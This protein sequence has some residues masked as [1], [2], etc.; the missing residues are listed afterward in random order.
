GGGTFSVGGF[1]AT[2]GGRGTAQITA[3]AEGGQLRIQHDDY[4]S[5]TGFDLSFVAGGTDGSA[6]LGVAAGSYVGQDVMGTIGGM[7]ATGLGTTLRGDEGTAVDGLI[8]SYTGEATGSA[9][10]VT[11]S[12]GIASL[13]QEVAEVL[14]GGETGSIDDIVDNGDVRIKRLNDRVDDIRDRLQARRDNL[15]QRF[16]RLEEAMALAQTQQ[17]WLSQQLASLTA[18]TQTGF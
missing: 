15:I 13:V 3:S 1:G 12:R 6:S 11:Y 18:Y 16:A 2:S 17:Q 9:G 5:A 10:S 4:G 8:V 7:S 14:L